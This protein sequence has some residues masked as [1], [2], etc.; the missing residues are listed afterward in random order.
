MG[1]WEIGT[2]SCPV[3]VF[4][5]NVQ[6]DP[7]APPSKFR[8]R[9][10]QGAALYPE[11]WRA[12]PTRVTALADFLAR[13]LHK[14]LGGAGLD[15][16]SVG[17]GW[18]GSKGGDI[19]IDA[20]TQHVVQRSSVVPTKDWVEARLSVALPAQGRSIEGEKAARLIC[21][22]LVGVVEQGLLAASLQHEQVL[23]HIRNIEDQE[24][25]RAQLA[26]RGLVAFVRN[27]AVLPRASGA[28]DRVMARGGVPFQAPP[29]GEVE[30]EVPN[31]GRVRGLGIRRGVTLIVGG[32]FHGKSTLLEALQVLG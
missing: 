28:D 13:R 22:E 3:S 8:V 31:M 2:A 11:A 21:R 20:P 10:A 14:L 26:A 32:G 18:H 29:E 6:S 4:I 12:S 30:L 7:Y 16:A 5:D 19:K 24:A 17:G 15:Q 9:V 25:L 23:E 27:G 1:R